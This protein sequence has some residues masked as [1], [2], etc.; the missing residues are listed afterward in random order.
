L[1]EGA[2]DFVESNPEYAGLLPVANVAIE[3]GIGSGIKPKK[4]SKRAEIVKKIMQD[5]G[6]SMIDAS[7][8]VKANNLY[9]KNN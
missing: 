3:K 4:N 7:K 8:Y 9:N 5:H 2:K 6:I 1:K